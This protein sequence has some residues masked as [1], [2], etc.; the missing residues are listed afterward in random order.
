MP[1]YPLSAVLHQD[2][3]CYAMGRLHQ[4]SHNL[5]DDEAAMMTAFRRL[6]E[7]FTDSEETVTNGGRFKRRRT[8]AARVYQGTSA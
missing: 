1:G 8:Y 7:G 4:Q 2:G 6:T 5:T 3:Q